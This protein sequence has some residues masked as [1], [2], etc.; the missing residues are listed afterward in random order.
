MNV[1][2]I[3]KR[4]VLPHSY[5]LT[6]AYCACHVHL[7]CLPQVTKTDSIYTQRTNNKWMCTECSENTFP[8]NHIDNENDFLSSLVENWQCLPNVPFALLPSQHFNPFEIDDN[9][10]SLSILDSDPDLQYYNDITYIESVSNCN[11][12]LE[13]TFS[14]KCEDLE[15]GNDSFSMLQINIR[16]IPK[17]LS[18]L[19]NYLCSLA[20]SFTV[21]GIS[22][23][24]LKES[25]ASCY[26][27]NGYNHFLQCR[28]ERQG[29]GVSIFV[30]QDIPVKN[31]P[32]FYRNESYIETLFIEISKDSTGL[33]KDTIIGMIYRPPNQDITMFQETLSIILQCIKRENKLLYLM[34]DFN[35]NL[36]ECERHIPS[37]EFI[38]TLYSFSIFPLITKPTRISDNSATLIDNIYFNDISTVST[39]NGIL[40]TGISD[41]LPIFS[42]NYKSKISIE[43]T[44]HKARIFSQKNIDKF[45]NSLQNVDWSGI[46]NNDNGRNAFS[47]FY[48]IYCRLY[49]KSFPLKVI[50]N[51]YYNRKTWLTEGIKKSIKIKNKLYMRQL[52]SPTDI[53]MKNRYKIYKRNLGKIIQKAERDHYDDLLKQNQQNSKK[54]WSILKDV[55]NKKK[56]RTTPSNFMI[57]N[58]SE[59]NKNIIANKFNSFFTN[60]GKDL[61]AKIPQVNINPLSYIP[62]SIQQSIFFNKVESEEVEKIIKSL[63]CASAGHDGI[64]A[65]VVKATYNSY[66]LP[67]VHICNLS[68]TQGFFPD[69][70]KLAKVIPI[71]KS[72]D[73]TSISNY[74]PVSILPLFSKILERLV[75]N[76]LISFISKHNILYKHQFGFRK[77]HSTNMALITLID[78]IALAIDRGDLVLGVF[79]DFQKAFDTVNHQIL[80]DK[81]Y[82]LGIRGTAHTWLK[83]YLRNRQQYVSYV[84]IESKKSIVTC[85]VPQGSI[86]GPLLFLIYVNDLIYVS[87]ELMPILFADDTNIFITGNSLDRM[88]SVMNNELEKIVEW[89]KANKLS[90]NVSKTKYMIFKSTQY[91]RPSCTGIFI[92]QSKIDSVEHIK[93]LG[94]VLDTKLRWDKHILILKGKISR[95]LG[96]I[97]KGKKYLNISS[98]I[99]LYYGMIYPHLLYCIE[100][101]GNASDIYLNTLF[102]LQK[103]AVK[104][105]K[106]KPYYFPSDIIF[107]ELRLLKLAQIHS[108][109]TLLFIFKYLKGSLPNVFDNFFKRN[110]NV[111]TRQTRQSDQLYIPPCR[112]SLYQKTIRVWGAKEWNNRVHGLNIQCSIHT[113][114]RNI[115]QLIIKNA[116]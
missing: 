26:S 102:K 74:R 53:T 39:F 87:D 40:F 17:N 18:K 73:A 58:K 89:L 72:G 54:L 29:G 44:V 4:N 113:F 85:G 110:T 52:K 20:H 42:I 45:K 55:I 19:E 24:W 104:I 68:I 70:M 98:L 81:L 108:Y 51:N 3:C 12:Y 86:L 60:I 79:L 88:A 61:A 56:S 38:E 30:K 99:T 33:A 100:S 75:Y 62:Q 67:L 27:L 13:N 22:E 64:H 65:K 34:G 36:L 84:D 1:C 10:E 97:S 94:V 105:I 47:E 90:L 59:S 14:K 115:K 21:I 83:D 82:K 116:H 114:K 28:K 103:R 112:T 80:L 9:S 6:C 96:A 95:G 106:S 63:K 111:I 49:N 57:D 37:S 48:S 107:Q 43:S 2:N 11:Y 23:T 71:Y 76:R 93:F 78:K 109:S 101:W 16:S 5:H 69:E 50:K 77:N 35:I 41:H 25:N 32:E 91:N 31:R 15:I 46:I 8:F 66:L 92:N 7:S